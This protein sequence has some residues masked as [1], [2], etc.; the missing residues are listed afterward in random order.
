MT[1]NGSS[2][3]AV[4]AEWEDPSKPGQCGSGGIWCFVAWITFTF[5]PG[6][7]QLGDNE[8]EFK[9]VNYTGPG[10]TTSPMGLIVEWSGCSF[11]A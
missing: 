11:T 6:H 5:P 10:V 2:V 4:M 9:I 7:W 8:I 3:L 1:I